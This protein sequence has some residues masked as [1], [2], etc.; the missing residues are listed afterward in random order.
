MRVGRAEKCTASWWKA[1]KLFEQ[2]CDE[3][4]G[5]CRDRIKGDLVYGP[6]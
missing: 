1:G 3:W 6:E 5:S 4:R 2:H